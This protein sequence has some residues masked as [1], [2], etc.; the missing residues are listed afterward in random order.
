L[1]RDAADPDGETYLRCLACA[2][3]FGMKPRSRRLSNE[4]LPVR[5]AR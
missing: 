5:R 2:R 1:Y 3:P 4:V